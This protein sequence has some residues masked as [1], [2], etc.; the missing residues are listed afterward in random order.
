MFAKVTMDPRADQG[1]GNKVAATRHQLPQVPAFS[2]TRLALSK[3]V[4]PEAVGTEDMCTFV[5][6]AQLMDPPPTVPKGKGLF[7]GLLSCQ[8]SYF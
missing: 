7:H 6:T 2:Q 3:S 8:V 1:M 5:P 4:K